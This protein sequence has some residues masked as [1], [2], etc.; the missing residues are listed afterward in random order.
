MLEAKAGMWV[1]TSNKTYALNDL[2]DMVPNKLYQLYDHPEYGLTF[3][4]DVGD[5]R[6][7]N[8]IRKYLDLLA[9]DTPTNITFT[10]EELERIAVLTTFIGGDS[11]CYKIGEKLDKLI[12]DDEL[13]D[14]AHLLTLKG[15]TTS[16]EC[17]MYLHGY[18]LKFEEN[19]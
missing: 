7:Y 14:M 11:I 17:G 15:P 8:L 1:G 10:Q 18:E 2:E 16:D 9:T 4:D 3:N 6:D 12:D 5:E 13:F 19:K